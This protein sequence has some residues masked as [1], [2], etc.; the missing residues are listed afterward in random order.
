MDNKQIYN[1]PNTNPPKVD[2][3]KFKLGFTQKQFGAKH[4]IQLNEQYKRF[5]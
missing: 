3:T 2:I 5:Q 4:K 1:H